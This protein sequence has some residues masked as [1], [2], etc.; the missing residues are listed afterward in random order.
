[1]IK[2][3]WLHQS[4]FGLVWISGSVLVGAAPGTCAYPVV[5]LAA[6]VLMARVALWQTCAGARRPSKGERQVRDDH[7]MS[8]FC[9]GSKYLRS[10]TK[11]RPAFQTDSLRGGGSSASGCFGIIRSVSPQSLWRFFSLSSPVTGGP[12]L[13]TSGHLRQRCVYASLLCR[14]GVQ[15]SGPFLDDGFLLFIFGFLP[16][17]GRD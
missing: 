16:G 14:A 3:I 15:T 9:T 6:A 17:S 11:T 8:T 2:K 5:I 13:G 7:V 12:V 10:S 1:M 4:A